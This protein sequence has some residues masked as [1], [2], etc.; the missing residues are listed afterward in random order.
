M[1]VHLAKSRDEKILSINVGEL[2]HL[3]QC[4]DIPCRATVCTALL[5]VMPHM[6]LCL[7]GRCS[8]LQV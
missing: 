4:Q 5:A 8:Q 2:Q 7:L 1:Y 6:V 3:S